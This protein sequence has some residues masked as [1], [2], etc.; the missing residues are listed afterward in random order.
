M[1]RGGEPTSST[2]SRRL[3]AYKLL[4][5]LKIRGPW[6]KSTK[7]VPPPPPS[8]TQVR[9]G[10][11]ASPMDHISMGEGSQEAMKEGGYGA[12]LPHGASGAGGAP[13]ATAGAGTALRLSLPSPSTSPSSPSPSPPCIQWFILPQTY[14][15]LYVNMVFDAI[16]YNTM[17]YVMLL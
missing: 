13:C 16:S 12:A 5:D 8:P 4:L 17:I 7:K 14:V 10:S 15:P 11:Y 6:Q 3:S 2:I 1:P 9:E